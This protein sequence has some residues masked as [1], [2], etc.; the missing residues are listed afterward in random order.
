MRSYGSFTFVTFQPPQQFIDVIGETIKARAQLLH[1]Y[2]LTIE[3]GIKESA[4][5][6]VAKKVG[7]CC[8]FVLNKFQ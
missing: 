1:E 5:F 6:L 8:Y 3:G 7:D 4:T 2:I